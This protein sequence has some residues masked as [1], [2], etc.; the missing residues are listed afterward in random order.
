[1]CVVLL[2]CPLPPPPPLLP[3]HGT[4]TITAVLWY[5]TSH[6]LLSTNATLSIRY[7]CHPHY[8]ASVPRIGGG[9]GGGGGMLIE[10]EEKGMEE[11]EDT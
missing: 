10:N 6:A 7:Y 3:S 9:G 8:T 5:G 2:S 4:D 1:M 11:P